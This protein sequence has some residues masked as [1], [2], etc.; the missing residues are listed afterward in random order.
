MTLEPFDA[1]EEKLFSLLGQRYLQNNVVIVRLQ[2][3]DLW[4]DLAFPTDRSH[5]KFLFPTLTSTILLK[6]PPHTIII[7]LMIQRCFCTDGVV[8]QIMYNVLAKHTL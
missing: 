8:M 2:L 5:P 7:I 3:L 1:V 4:E 6:L